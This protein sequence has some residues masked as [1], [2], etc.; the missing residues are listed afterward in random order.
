MACDV[1]VLGALRAGRAGV[2]EGHL[3]RFHSENAAPR[4]RGGWTEREGCI[5]IG[6]L[7]DTITIEMQ[8]EVQT[9]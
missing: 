6:L 3:F 9:E 8:K 7:W 2:Q 5:A 1:V 4:R